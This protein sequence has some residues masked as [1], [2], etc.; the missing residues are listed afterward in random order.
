MERETIYVQGDWAAESPRLISSGG[1]EGGIETPIT[2]TGGGSQRGHV[3]DSRG[4]MWELI[5]LGRSSAANPEDFARLGEL[6]VG[7]SVVGGWRG[8]RIVRGRS[9]SSTM[10]VPAA[11]S[12]KENRLNSPFS[13]GCI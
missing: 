10:P 8:G 12:L 13:T 11:R 9:S 7:Q 6:Q 2:I 3:V 1:S 4:P 5:P